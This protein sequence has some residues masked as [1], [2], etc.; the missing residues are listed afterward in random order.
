M[1][2]DIY[3]QQAARYI[4]LNHFWVT[5]GK[6]G[7]AIYLMFLAVNWRASVVQAGVAV[8][9]LAAFFALS[10]LPVRG[11][12]QH[13]Y[14]ERLR[15]LSRERT[16]AIFF[17]ATLIAVGVE[18]GTT[19]ILTTFLVEARGFAAGAAQAGLI[20]YIA[21][22]GAGRLLTGFLPG[23]ERIPRLTIVLFGLCV[24]VFALL[25]FVN[26]GTLTWPAIFVAGV[27]LS[28][29][30]PLVLSL[31]GIRYPEM[32]GHGAGRF[33]G[34][35]PGG[36]DRGTG[37][38]VVGQQ[39]CRAAGDHGDLP[40]DV[41]AGASGCCWATATWPA[42]RRWLHLPPSPSRSKRPAAEA[43]TLS[44]D[45]S[46]GCRCGALASVTRPGVSVRPGA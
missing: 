3:P 42:C 43:R 7:L 1:L 44:E 45:Q 36:R 25:F 19:G 10:Y 20:V 40:G 27:A 16:V 28:A 34:S 39:P 32:S 35:H 38:D 8:L 14:A 31:G 6:L 26:L 29:C 18:S 5:I 37:P 46:S 15:V 17:L 13:S 30:L 4:S 23:T 11:G 12:P 21:G 33:E 2:I 41:L 9:V 22:I 24:P